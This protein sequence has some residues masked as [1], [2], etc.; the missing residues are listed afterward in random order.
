MEFCGNNDEK[1]RALQSHLDAKLVVRGNQLKIIGKPEDVKLTTHVVQEILSVMRKGGGLT[2]QQFRRAMRYAADR[3]RSGL[4]PS[5]EALLDGDGEAPGDGE[6]E[7]TLSELFLD[8]IPVPLKRRRLSPLTPAQKR[9]ITTIKDNDVVFS[10]GPAGTGKTYLAM[11]MAVGALTAGTVSRIILCRPAVEAGERLGF[12]PGDLA[13]K[14]DPYVRPLWDALYEMMES[15][16]I[17]HHIETGVIEIAPLAF[18]RGRTLN[19]AF[20]ILDEGQNTSIEQMKMFLT[21]LGFESKA[22]I[23][24]DITQV[25]LPQGQESGLAHAQRVL[26]NIEGIGFVQFTGRDVVRHPLL[27]KIIQAYDREKAARLERRNKPSAQE[28]PVAP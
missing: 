21:R 14:F 8:E 18:M 2:E 6:P 10:I 15:E 23:T 12:L 7:A 4:P 3:A 22:V 16:R 11:A 27:T 19:N 28:Q 17:R 5:G 1:I 20:V 26:G 25:D 13:Q 24:G 9:Y